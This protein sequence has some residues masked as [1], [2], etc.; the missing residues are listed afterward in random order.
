MATRGGKTVWLNGGLRVSNHRARLSKTQQ[1]RGR[2][3]RHVDGGGRGR[4]HFT[5]PEWTQ[6]QGGA[7]SKTIC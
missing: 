2:K 4:R 1:I 3:K 6:R 7:V 5:F